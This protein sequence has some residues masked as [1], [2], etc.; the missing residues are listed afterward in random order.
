MTT[1]VC[2]LVTKGK[3]GFD[4]QISDLYGQQVESDAK[5]RYES[6]SR[7]DQV[8]L[9]ASDSHT[10]EVLVEPMIPQTY[11]RS[12]TLF[13]GEINKIVLQPRSNIRKRL[14]RRRAIRQKSVLV[15]GQADSLVT[16]RAAPPPIIVSRHKPGRPCPATTIETSARIKSIEHKPRAWGTSISGVSIRCSFSQSNCGEPAEQQRKIIQQSLECCF[17]DA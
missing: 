5:G 17:D 9:V 11:L 16:S 7:T 15:G 4:N 13:I 3:T 2:G 1:Q 12:S 10:K 8:L 6:T 14:G